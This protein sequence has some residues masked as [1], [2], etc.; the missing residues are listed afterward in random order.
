[1]TGVVILAVQ[2]RVGVAV[3]NFFPSISDKI[4]KLKGGD[5][6]AWDFLCRM[7]ESGLVGKTRLLLK[8]SSLKKKVVPEDLVQET[9]LR[10][11]KSRESFRGDTTAQFSKWLLQILRNHFIDSC[12]A[13]KRDVSIIT[14]HGEQLNSDEVEGGETPS[15]HAMN[16]EQESQLHVSL[17]RLDPSERKIIDLRCFE[18]MKFCEIAEATGININ[19]VAG[20]YRRSIRKLSK[21]MAEPFDQ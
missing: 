9:L 18:G 13:I 2:T 3:K 12:G 6:D 4:Q 16:E 10:A 20:I 8:T 1:M 21:W 14:W 11:W 19:T 7:F 5:Q 17:C 15:Y